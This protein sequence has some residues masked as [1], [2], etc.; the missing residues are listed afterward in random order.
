MDS[1][2]FSTSVLVSSLRFARKGGGLPE[3]ARFIMPFTE[4]LMTVLKSSELF[5]LLPDFDPWAV[6]EFVGLADLWEVGEWL[7]EEMAAAT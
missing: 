1:R 6:L 7:G 3:S 4:N 5:S 2:K